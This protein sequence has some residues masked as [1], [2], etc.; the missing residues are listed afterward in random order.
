MNRRMS[1]PHA[2]RRRALPKLAATLALVMTASL[3]HTTAAARADDFTPQDV[4][5]EKVVG[6]ADAGPAGRAPADPA[7]AAAAV[8]RPAPAWPRA[9]AVEVALPRPTVPP[10]GTTA[11]AGGAVAV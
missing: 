5:A 3:V 6:G 9:G 4:Q 7:A 10:K 8:V 2:R 1:S 11:V